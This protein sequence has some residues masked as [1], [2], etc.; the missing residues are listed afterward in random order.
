MIIIVLRFVLRHITAVL[1][2]FAVAWWGFFY[3]PHTPSW[4]VLRLKLAVDGRDGAAAAQYVDFESVVQHAGEEMIGAKSGGDPL[5]SLVGQAA[6]QFLSRP[7]AQMLETWA[8]QKVDNGAKDVQMPAVGVIG[9]IALM[10]RDGDIA[11]TNFTDH[12]KQT[13]EVRMA[14]ERGGWQ[15]TEVKNIRQLLEK[16]KRHEEKGFNFSP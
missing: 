11:W 9:A 15:V 1:I 4:A 8:K 7:M 14:R 2:A 5:G 13:W 12:K 16:L 3:L 6:I 10:H